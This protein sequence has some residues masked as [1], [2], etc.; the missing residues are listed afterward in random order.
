MER[1]KPGRQFQPFARLVADAQACR[2]TRQPIDASLGEFREIAA[3]EES[4]IADVQSAGRQR[5][6]ASQGPSVRRAG[7]VQQYRGGLRSI[8]S[9]AEENLDRGQGRGIVGAGAAAAT[10]KAAG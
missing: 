4:Q 8:E 6:E 9:E 7:R 1:F 10:G 5:I 3:I 2:Q